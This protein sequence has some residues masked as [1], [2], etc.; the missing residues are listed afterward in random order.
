M[1]KPFQA[2]DNILDV[3]GILRPNNPFSSKNKIIIYGKIT[4][5]NCK[6]IAIKHKEWLEP[7]KKIYILRA[8]NPPP[9]KKKILIE[10]SL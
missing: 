1:F 8:N 7:P 2:P 5:K 4:I 6:V 9:Q 10:I 3:N